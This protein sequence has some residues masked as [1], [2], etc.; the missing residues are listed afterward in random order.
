VLG[1]TCRRECTRQSEQHDLLAAR[2]IVNLEFVGADLALGGFDFDV[3]VE[4]AGREPV[5]NLDHGIPATARRRGASRW[6]ADC[7]GNCVQA[8]ARIVASLVVGDV[9]A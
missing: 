3:L 9:K 7:S 5:A 6:T 4:T 2:Q 1:G 8:R